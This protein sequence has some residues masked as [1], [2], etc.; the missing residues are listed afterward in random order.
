MG[1]FPNSNLG[2]VVMINGDDNVSEGKLAKKVQA[3]FGKNWNIDNRP[4][5]YCGATL[6]CGDNTIGVWRKSADAENTVLR[7]GFTAN[8][9]HAE[10]EWL[11]DK[12]YYCNDIETYMDGNT[13]KWDG[14]FK[15]GNKKSALWRNWDSDDFHKKWEE[16]NKQG[17][18]LI[19]VETYM[20]VGS[21]KWA[22]LFLQMD[23]GYALHRGLNHDQ[24]HDKWMEYGKKGLKLIDIERYGDDWAGV[25][26]AGPDVAMYR[27]YDT[28]GFKQLRR[29]N[30]EKGWKLI[31]VDTY[32]TDGNRKWS[33]LWE[34]TS[35]AERYIFGVD[36]CDWATTYH[37]AYLAD[38]YELIDIETY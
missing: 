25:W 16:M 35:T 11:L 21:R 13:R 15:K 32:I 18:R 34:K 26:V 5:N 9:F 8:E 24:M 14:I 22:G 4:I 17:L 23:G 10:W 29:D 38:G 7:R 19:D 20:D 27:N 1:F 30:N 6:K 12:G 28:E 3:L 2:V 33:G 31:D 36:F 37:N